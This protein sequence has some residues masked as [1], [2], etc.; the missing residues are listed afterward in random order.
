MDRT[1][2]YTINSSHPITVKAYLRTRGYSAQNIIF[3][4]KT[5]GAI[6]VNHEPAPVNRMLQPGDELTIYIHETDVSP[7]EPVELPLSILY[8]DEDLLV[9]NK[10]AGMPCHPSQ[11]N[12]GNSLANALAHYYAA[13]G[14]PFVFRCVNRLDKDTSGLTI[15]AK[16]SISAGILSSMQG[17]GTATTESISQGNLRIG[18]EMCTP[19]TQIPFIN[20]GIRREYLAIV[21]GTPTPTEGTISVPIGRAPDSIIA[22]VPDP[23]NGDPAITHYRVIRETKRHSLVSL[24]LE[25]GRTHQIRVH[26]KYLGYPLI[27]DHLYH[28]DMQYINRHALHARSLDFIHPITGKAMHFTTP[29]PPDM[30]AV[31]NL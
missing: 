27:G 31:L 18:Q 1:I 20:K 29:L 25:T 22:R 3:L 23:E 2:T 11:N 5:P 9:I 8:E 28:P 6:S 14:K 10:A 17:H 4:K 21:A 12:H 15:V 13:Q 16:H 19:D 26:M 30:E 7:I 24:I